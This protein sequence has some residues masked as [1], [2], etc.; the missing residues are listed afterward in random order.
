[1]DYG[2][3]FDDERQPMKA[4]ECLCGSRYC[5]GGRR[6]LLRKERRRSRVT[7]TAG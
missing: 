6:H 2:I 7:G 5:R 1:Q 4:F 3:D